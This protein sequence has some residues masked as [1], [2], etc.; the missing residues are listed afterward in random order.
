MLNTTHDFFLIRTQAGGVS[1]IKKM[2]P[3]LILFLTL[4][5]G[6]VRIKCLFQAFQM[7]PL[8]V[9][10]SIINSSPVLVMFLR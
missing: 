6:A 1:P 3:Y 8:H 9:A 4:I 7:I 10:H 5:V 2:A